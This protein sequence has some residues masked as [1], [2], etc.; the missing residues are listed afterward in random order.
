M[1]ECVPCWRVVADV[2]RITIVRESTQGGMLDSIAPLY[3]CECNCK[4]TQWDAV[5]D[6]GD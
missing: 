6:S 4:E 3:I 1:V 2:R 5:Q